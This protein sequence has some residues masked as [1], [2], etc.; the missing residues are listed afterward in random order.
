MRND[1]QPS[2]DQADSRGTQVDRRPGLPQ[3]P[4]ESPAAPEQGTPAR[5]EAPCM[6]APSVRRRFAAP[7][8]RT[9]ART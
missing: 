9:A 4:P 3:R 8:T 5:A 6:L 7:G 1:V 2:M